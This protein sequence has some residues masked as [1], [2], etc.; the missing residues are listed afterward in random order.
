MAPAS[1]AALDTAW[2]IHE[3]HVDWTGKV[4]A[5]ASF[6]LALESAATATTIALTAQGRVFSAFPSPVECWL[7]WI[8]LGG[9]GVAAVFALIV[10]APR[11]RGSKAKRQPTRTSST[12]ATHGTGTPRNWPLTLTSETC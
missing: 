12:S 9:L 4:D 2:R 10:V 3:A 11:L 6:P 1:S 7:Y 8:G 5:K